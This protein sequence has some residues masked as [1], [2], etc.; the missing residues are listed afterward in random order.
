MFGYS[1]ELKLQNTVSALNLQPDQDK[2]RRRSREGAALETLAHGNTRVQ[3]EG[4][5]LLFEDML[6]QLAR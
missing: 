5:E 4:L 2:G 1:I 3:T 6:G